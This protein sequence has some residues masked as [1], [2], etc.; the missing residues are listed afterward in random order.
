[1]RGGALLCALVA[2]GLL[3]GVV[4]LAQLGG[5]R[6]AVLRDTAERQQTVSWIIPARRG[7]ILDARGRVLAGTVRV[8]SVYVDPGVVEDTRFTAYS[9]GPLLGI[10]PAELEAS[11]RAWRGQTRFVWLKRRIGDQELGALERMISG[12]ALHGVGLRDE[13]AREYPQQ[14]EQAIAAHVLG[15][16]GLDRHRL[17]ATAEHYEDLRGLAG[18]EAH[19][20]AVLAGT[21]GKRSVTVDRERRPLRPPEELLEPAEDG[22]TLVLTIDSV[23]Q[24]AA[25]KALRAAVAE[26]NAVWG[27]VVVL[28]PQ[29]GEVLA[30]ATVPDFEPSAAVPPGDVPLSPEEKAELESLWRNRAV[31]DAYEP[32]SIFKPFIAA[33]AIDDGQT[34][35]DE[36]FVI[37][38][39][40]RDFGSRTVH[41]T[42]AYDRL[43][44]CE[45][46]SKSSNIGM[47]LLGARCK[48]ERLHAYVRR[49][50]FG[51][52]T[53]IGLPGEHA[54]LV[55]PPEQWNP[56]FSPQSVAM[57]H[58]IGVTSI[59]VAT[60][61][62]ALANGGVL[63]RPRIVRGVIGADG[64]VLADYSEPVVVRRVLSESTANEFRRRALVETVRSGT[65]K[66]A[67]LPGYQVFGKT[68]TAQ[69]SEPGR[70]YV[71]GVYVGSFVGG[72][73]ADKPRA[74]V[75]VS[76]YKP[77]GKAYYG[78]QV[79]APAVKEILA[80]TLAYMRVPP[81]PSGEGEAARVAAQRR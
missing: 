25:Q 61:F 9:V 11:L 46:I 10:D 3:V 30:M 27:T 12:R 58:E 48:A 52:V 54:G 64:G 37:N 21:P 28:D 7:E 31:A 35:L 63:L 43:R 56:R 55:F 59:Q 62:A 20:N 72:A 22:A 2:S 68:G 1:M 19:Y 5:S 18:L 42:H 15:F 34:S 17:G 45:I 13:W 81:E 79:A 57:G 8:P 71:D 36:E 80:A 66:P 24:C 60:A 51:E 77:R 16:V 4:R 70:G 44:V 76:I 14:G 41:D 29:T 53:G 75:L 73:P 50:G 65:G 67:A 39:P 74:V 40:A 69:V 33:S 49:F 26:H 6:H 38:G 23:V 47:G 32:G 78:A